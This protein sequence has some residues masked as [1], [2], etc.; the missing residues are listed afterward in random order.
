MSKC[1][2]FRTLNWK[3]LYWTAL[4]PKDWDCAVGASRGSAP[5]SKMT[6]VVVFMSLDYPHT[7]GSAHVILPKLYPERT[8]SDE[9]S[10]PSH[11]G[12]EIGQSTRG[13]VARSASCLTSESWVA[14]TQTGD[15]T[16][17]LRL[18]Q[19]RTCCVRKTR[20]C[21]PH[22]YAIG[23]PNSGGSHH[24]G[25]PG[26]VDRSDSRRG[27]DPDGDRPRPGLLRTPRRWPYGGDFLHSLGDA[28]RGSRV[29]LSRGDERLLLRTQAQRPGALPVRPGHLAGVAR[30]HGDPRGLDLQLR[31][32]ELHAGGRHLGDRL[33]HDP[34]GG[35]GAPAPPHAWRPRGPTPRAAP[36]AA[37]VAHQ[38]RS[39][40]RALEDS[41]H[42][43]LER[44]RGRHA[45]DRVV[46]DHSVDRGD[47]G[48]LLVRHGPHDGA[49]APQPDVPAPR[50]RRHRLVRRAA[51]HQPVRRSAAVEC[52]APPP[53]GDAGASVIPQ[54]QQVSGVSGLFVDD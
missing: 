37:A 52:G 35:V 1:C 4:R 41:L 46:L 9:S 12:L 21:S 2:V 25:V 40:G 31:F 49:G 27:D 8:S 54:Y 42:R 14:F 16:A 30:A 32:Q 51:R 34:G 29:H 45:A 33:V 44:A 50:A 24:V 18:N 48:G 39:A 20:S 53:P 17:M 22:E 7:S 47:G 26:R 3:D 13:N 23:R 38:S 28:F 43:L 36:R 6:R 11:G 10:H 15:S 19:Y 5:S